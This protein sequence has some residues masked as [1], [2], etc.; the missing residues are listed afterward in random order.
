[1]LQ[2]PIIFLGLAFWNVVLFAVT[3]TMGLTRH[4]LHGLALGVLT[5]IYTCL[6]HCIVMMHFMGSGKGIKEAIA[7]HGV[8]DDPRT[9]Y[10]RRSRTLHAR[11]SAT[12]TLACLVILVNVWLGGWAHTSAPQSS[13]HPWHKWFAWFAVAYNLYAFATEYRVIRANTALIREVN[14]RITAAETSSTPAPRP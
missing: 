11:A 4:P 7:S 10:A 6:T 8:A 13:S 2:M 14:A 5:G 9:G 12:A 3:I 1:M